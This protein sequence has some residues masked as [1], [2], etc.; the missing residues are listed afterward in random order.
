VALQIGCNNGAYRL[1]QESCLL[2]ETSASD[3]EE[4]RIMFVYDNDS[5]LQL[6][7]EHAE[8][9]ADEMRRSRRLTRDVAGFPGRARLGELLRRAARRGR[10]KESEKTI[11]AY[12]A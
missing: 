7:R 4:G 8:R 3:R 5:R 12:D 10:M 6:T 9:L 1:Q 2:E 11:P